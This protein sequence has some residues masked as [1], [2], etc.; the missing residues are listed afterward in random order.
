MTRL[1]PDQVNAIPVHPASQGFDTHHLAVEKYSFQAPLQPAVSSIAFVWSHGT[2]F[3]KEMLHPLMKRFLDALRRLP[4]YEQ[5]D[6]VFYAWDSRNHGDSARLNDGHVNTPGCMF[7]GLRC[8]YEKLYFA[9][10]EN[11]DDDRYLD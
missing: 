11:H 6:L 5:I 3:H 10:S 7:L 1:T 4:Q 8:M 9:D 2:S